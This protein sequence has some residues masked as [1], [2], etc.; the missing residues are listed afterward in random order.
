[1]E[2]KAI[3][4]REISTEAECKVKEVK[5]E[6][7]AEREILVKE[8]LQSLHQ[9]RAY[10]A[11]SLGSL[12]T[13]TKSLKKDGAGASRGRIGTAQVQGAAAPDAETRTENWQAAPSAAPDVLQV[14]LLPPVTVR[15]F[16]TPSRLSVA[17]A[18]PAGLSSAE[19]NGTHSGGGTTTLPRVAS[20]PSVPTS[21]SPPNRGS[22]AAA[23]SS[24]GS[25]QLQLATDLVQVPARSNGWFEADRGRLSKFIRGPEKLKELKALTRR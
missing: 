3:E 15:Q 24:T 6:K 8:A 9:L 5:E 10:L 12:Q 4:I 2:L 16:H 21:K 17:A 20:M 14:S 1:M 23:G 19:P 7:K 22:T 25:K 13:D 11:L 18:T